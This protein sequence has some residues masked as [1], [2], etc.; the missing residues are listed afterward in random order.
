VAAI[1]T[2][3]ELIDNAYR[4]YVNQ[5][6]DAI[7]DDQAKRRR[8][9]L[10]GQW[11][12][13]RIWTSAPL[14]FK[15]S[16]ADAIA[17]A[18]GSFTFPTD[19]AGMGQEAIL[20]VTGGTGDPLKFVT[21]SELFRSRAAYPLDAAPVAYSMYGLS[22]AGL[23]QAA[24]YPAG[25]G[26]TLELD[27][28]T[29][30][31]PALIDRP[32]SPSVATGAAGALTGT[33]YV[34]VT[35]VHAGGETELGIV[36]QAVSPSSQKIAVTGIPTSQLRDVTS[37]KLYLATAQDLS[38]AAL[39]TTIADNVTTSYTGDGAAS[40]TPP[41][42]ATAVTGAEQFPADF[43]DS[44]FVDGLSHRIARSK[45]DVRD[46]KWATD[47]LEEVRRMWGEIQPGQAEPRRMPAYGAG[48]R[49]GSRWNLRSLA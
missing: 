7:L 47:W 2:F 15:L 22:S 25:T 40:G 10:H 44:L 36:S 5:G 1:W 39:W 17:I 26:Y 18:S 3:G 8:A 33:Y 27:G 45:G 35:F 46:S 28:Y 20:Y 48:A 49:R 13:K 4:T 29:R 23:Y 19:F 43:L 14:W 30:R 12:G 37:R 34:A 24:V 21:P 16:S 42:K 32:T 11:V 9:E 31:C 41:T 38:D 6:S